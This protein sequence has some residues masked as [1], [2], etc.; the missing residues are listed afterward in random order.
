MNSVEAIDKCIQRK[1]YPRCGS[2]IA[3]LQPKVQPANRSKAND[4]CTQSDIKQLNIRVWLHSEG[5]TRAQATGGL[6]EN[7][8]RRQRRRNGSGLGGQWNW[9]GDKEMF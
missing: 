9:S 7:M 6:E 8:L 3:L 1:F 5:H 4:C 2:E